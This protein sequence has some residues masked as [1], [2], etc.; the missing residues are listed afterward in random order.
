MVFQNDIRG[1]AVGVACGVSGVFQQAQSCIVESD[2]VRAFVVHAPATP[3]QQST[4]GLKPSF[5]TAQL[6]HKFELRVFRWCF[7][8]VSMVFRWRFVG[9]DVVCEMVVY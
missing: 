9:T 1:V 5:A 4:F 2:R 8:G 3:P 7:G 6:E